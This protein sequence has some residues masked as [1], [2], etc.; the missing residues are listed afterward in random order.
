MNKLTLLFLLFGAI[1]ACKNDE[2]KNTYTISGTI[3]HRY[4]MM[5]GFPD[6]E[7]IDIPFSVVLSLDDQIIST[8]EG[9]EFTFSGLEEGRSYTIQVQ[10][11]NSHNGLTALDFVEIRKYI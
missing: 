11:E 2:V 6:F 4:D 3:E 9:N 10:S 5:I 1:S 7:W 8:M